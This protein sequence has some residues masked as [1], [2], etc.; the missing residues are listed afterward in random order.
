MAEAIE[1]GTKLFCAKKGFSE[2]FIFPNR[3]VF[4]LD[5]GYLRIYLTRLRE[6]KPKP[7]PQNPHYSLP[8]WGLGIVWPLRPATQT[9]VETAKWALP[10]MQQPYGPEFKK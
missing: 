8:S 7:I 1:G 9:E 2:R 3:M 4:K 6:K 5:P 10:R